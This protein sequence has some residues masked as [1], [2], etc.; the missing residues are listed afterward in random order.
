LERVVNDLPSGAIESSAEMRAA[1][2]E[3]AFALLAEMTHDFAAGRD[4]RAILHRG[5]GLIVAH[6]K[7][8][9]GSFWLV[10]GDELVCQASVGPNP[11]EGLR[12]PRSAGVI[13]RAVAERR[14]QQVLDVSQD[15]N[16]SGE[17]DSLSGFETRS[18]LCTPLEFNGEVLGA[19]EVINKRGG[20]GCFDE[21]D[22]H[23]LRVLASSAALAL[24]NARLATLQVESERVR[25]D[26]ELAGEIQRSLLPEPPGSDCHVHG[27]N[28]PHRVVSGD[29]YDI[30][31]RRVGQIAFCL[32]DVSGKGMNAALL[33]S[34][35]ASLFHFLAKQGQGPAA[36]LR[37]VNDEIHET[38]TRGMFV[39]LVVGLFDP[40][41]GRVRVVNAGHE[42][43]L[44]RTGAGA[45]HEIE[46]DTPPVGVLETEVSMAGLEE[47]SLDLE[48]GHLYVFSDG[49]TEARSVDGEQLGSAGLRTLIDAFAD[50][51]LTKRL[52]SM[53]ER[54]AQLETRDDMT[55]LA[56]EDR[57]ALES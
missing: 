28:L 30:V 37:V 18:L 32:G 47:R 39:T 12:L 52:E 6:L 55:L 26:L 41:S 57:R 17:A 48:G 4:F 21:Q 51:H 38:V 16:F 50:L 49:M 53:M 1:R 22:A 46:A 42:P 24:A 23:P 8:E 45:Y 3:S 13:G 31:A 54:V 56:L 27:I 33:M 44:W 19:I 10:E 11:I 9:V 20:S 2:I 14:C 15:Q 29:F 25:R 5:L 7:A 35:T 40:E 34:K 43:P 36:I